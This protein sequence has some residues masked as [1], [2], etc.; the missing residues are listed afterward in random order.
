MAAINF[1]Y[2]SNKPEAAL[3]VRLL[4]THDGTNHV[5]G[6]RSK[7]NVTRDYWNTTHK[8]EISG[9]RDVE[10]RNEKIRV[11]NELAEISGAVLKAFEAA[12]TKIVN[13]QWLKDVLSPK[14]ESG[15]DEIPRDFLGYIDYYLAYR[16]SDLTVTGVRRVNVTKHKMQRLQAHLGRAILIKDIHEGFKKEFQKYSNAERYGQNTQQREL[17]MIKT[18]CY[19]ARYMGL[20]THHQLDGLKLKKQAVNHIYLNFD[21]IETIAE[22]SLPSERLTNARDWLL[23]SCYTGQ[24][25]SDFM[26]FTKE[27]IRTDEGKHLLEFKQQKT[28][29]L[30]TIPISKQ[31]RE[32]LGKRGGEFPKAIT[33][34]K[35]NDFIKIIARRAGLHGTET[36]KRRINIAKK[37]EKARYRDVVGEYPKWR[38]VSSHIGR[39]SFASNYYGKVPTSHLINIT[40]HGS[41]TQ[42]LNYIKKSNKDMAMDAYEYFN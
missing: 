12:D 1:L 14:D 16:K 2:R 27:M 30:M 10:K 5:L 36:G 9:V 20:E 8:K 3:T 41:E 29:K 21:E 22:L 34:Q 37:G 7:I 24:R 31:V 28:G 26:R 25:V 4:F 40:G 35:Y 13:K 11:V 15:T 32:I 33:D 6:V 39:R 42:F 18:I 19:H 38:L 23:I 17:V